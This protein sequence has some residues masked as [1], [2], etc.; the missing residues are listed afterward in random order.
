MQQVRVFDARGEY[1][2]TEEE[3]RNF[4]FREEVF[5]D[6]V[7]KPCTGRTKRS[8]F[9]TSRRSA[10]T[11]IPA[12]PFPAWSTKALLLTMRTSTRSKVMT[13]DQPLLDVD[14]TSA[15]LNLLTPR[16]VNR[17]GITLPMSTAKT[18]KEKRENSQL[19]QILIPELVVVHP[20]PASFWRKT[21]TLPCILYD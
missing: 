15:R 12:P 20:F 3:R 18:K 8:S 13:D 19:K 2:P 17:K 21:V 6:A 11:R 9:T 14:H 1:E 16:Y 5:K 4:V 10:T 7:I